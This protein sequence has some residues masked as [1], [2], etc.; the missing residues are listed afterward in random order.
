MYTHKIRSYSN[1]STTF[2]HHHHHHHPNHQQVLAPAIY[3]N[4]SARF[5]IDNLFLSATG[6]RFIT[7][8]HCHHRRARSANS[9]N[10]DNARQILKRKL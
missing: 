9:V 2:H 3:S 6:T 1:V 5:I 10:S 7:R 8:F 4:N